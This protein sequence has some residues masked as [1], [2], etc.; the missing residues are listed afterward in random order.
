MTD[1][2]PSPAPSEQPDQSPELEPVRE[3]VRQ[4]QA[5]LAEVQ[6]EELQPK[7]VSYVEATKRF[8]ETHEESPDNLQKLAE[9]TRRRQIDFA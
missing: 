4:R 7:Q 3:T 8:W 1:F 6:A 5:L 9:W 2:S